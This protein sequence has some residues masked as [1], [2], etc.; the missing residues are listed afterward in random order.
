MIRCFVLQPQCHQYLV[1]ATYRGQH[2]LRFLSVTASTALGSKNDD[3]SF[4]LTETTAA[5]GSLDEMNCLANTRMVTATNPSAVN[6]TAIS[7]SVGPAGHAVNS[8]KSMRKNGHNMT[9]DEE[10]QQQQQRQLRFSSVG[11]LYGTTSA[12]SRPGDS[13]SSDD[14]LHRLQ[15]AH[16]VVVGLGGVGSWAA[17]ALCRSGIGHLTLIDLDDICISNTNRQLHATVATIGQMKID[18][19]H[20]R[21]QQINPQCHV[22]LIHDFVSTDN[23]KDMLQK[24]KQQHP[25][26]T[27]FCLDAIDGSRSKTALMVAC[28]EMAIPIVTCG[29]SAG[30]TDPTQFVVKDLTQVQG[31][32]LLGTCRKNMRRYHGFPAGVDFKKEKKVKPWN[33]PA[34]YSTE[35]QRSIDDVDHDSSSLR[36]CDGALGTACFVTGTSGFVAASKVVEMIANGFET[37]QTPKKP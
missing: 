20:D 17:E 9:K 7:S 14:I 2:Y 16:V 24:Q 36:R 31:D 13:S 27:T 22:D 19:M 8:R 18:V 33:I 37:L 4:P 6:S 26:T 11:R 23:V 10:Q 1:M 28:V 32:P 5:A 3:A 12:G 15:R 25:G 21:L 34:V 35:P 30:R 29:G